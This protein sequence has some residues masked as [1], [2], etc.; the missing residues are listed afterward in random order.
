[1]WQFSPSTGRNILNKLGSTKC[2]I[3]FTQLQFP[4]LVL[5]SFQFLQS[6][7]KSTR[8]NSG[9]HTKDVTFKFDSCIWPSLSKYFCLVNLSWYSFNGDYISISAGWH[10]TT[11]SAVDNIF[12]QLLCSIT[13][14]AA[15]LP[16][17]Q[18]LFFENEY[19]RKVNAMQCGEFWYNQ[20]EKGMNVSW[21]PR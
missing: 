12:T 4:I 2:N 18:Q 19:P 16:H 5:E 8:S 13:T 7:R 6:D 21:D 14:Y 17:V 3:L 1:M 15:S 10:N 11:S 20:Y 9:R